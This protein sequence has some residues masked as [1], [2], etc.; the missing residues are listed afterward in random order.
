MKN[1]GMTRPSQIKT[2]ERKGTRLSALAFAALSVFLIAPASFAVANN[3]SNL[4]KLEDKFFHKTYEKELMDA[5]LDRIEKMVFG[6]AKD[7]DDAARLSSLV[8]AVPNL[9]GGEGSDSAPAQTARKGGGA[10]GGGS[11]RP[12][13]TAPQAEEE[14]SDP[15]PIGNYP[16]IDAIEKKAFAGKTYSQEPVNQRLARLET[17]YFGKPSSSTDLTD[18]TDR[19]KAQS[20]ID[21][22][23]NAPLNADW[24]DEDDEDPT[25]IAPPSPVAR[26][27]GDSKTFSGRDMREDFRKAGLIPQTSMPGSGAYG[28]MGSSGSAGGRMGSG[29]GSYGSGSYGMGAGTYGGGA[30]PAP[31]ARPAITSQDF[32]DE[33]DDDLP[34]PKSAMAPRTAPDIRASSPRA[35]GMG[36][37]SQ[38]TLMENEVFNKTFPKDA[39]PTRLHRLEQSLYPQEKPWTDRALP[40]RV[41]RLASVI[42]ISQ[43]GAGGS[44]QRV[45]QSPQP[46]PSYSDD[47]GYPPAAPSIK[48]RGNGG[49]GKIINSIGNLIGGGFVG[50][51][52]I[53]SGNVVTDPRT[54]LLLDTV[55]GNLIDPATGMVVGQRSVQRYGTGFG[56][57]V[58]TFGN[59]FSTGGLGIGTG[60]MRFGGGGMGMPMGGYGFGGGMWP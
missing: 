56:S 41:N 34:P 55:T 42:Q 18:R 39:L 4:L 57:G 19:L 20:G 12:P 16:A 35:Q 37:N 10:T 36:L 48:R 5:R 2:K 53:Q 58:G 52:P 47:D 59:G 49:L 50:G 1:T 23:K 33:D 11:A 40:D 13:A 17:K 29:S 7:G 30:A 15:A 26:R 6:E 43:G 21:I 3:D 46:A 31:R 45:A 51:Y 44:S 22:T 38:V 60:G 8:Q 54:G 25:N 28:G 24:A 14:E 9:N 32:D 27:G